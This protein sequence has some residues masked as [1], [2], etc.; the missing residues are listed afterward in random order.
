MTMVHAGRSQARTAHR[1][2][3]PDPHPTQRPHTTLRLPL[4][5]GLHSQATVGT[6]AAALVAVA[7]VG[8]RL[9]QVA[10]GLSL[11]RHYAATHTL[12][13][14]QHAIS[15]RDGLRMGGRL[16][17]DGL[18]RGVRGLYRQ[19]LHGAEHGGARG[20]AKGLA[21]GAVGLVVTP[22][23][24]VAGGTAKAAEGLAADCS[25]VTPEGMEHVRQAKL[26]RRV[27]QPRVLG[28]GSVLL[29]YPIAPVGG[30]SGEPAVPTVV[31]E[32]EAAAAGG[33]AAGGSGGEEPA[34]RV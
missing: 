12:E 30:D 21:R 9:E 1:S 8:R 27:R 22:L 18:V 19:P 34:L 20:F 16:V 10:V 7:G 4:A 11:D 32:E 15:T 28:P 14:Q 5:A 2:A 33:G 31:E 29:P 26:R 25:R 17:G 3:D 24:G 23:A 6:T 13:A